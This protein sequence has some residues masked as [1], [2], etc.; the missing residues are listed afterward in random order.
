[1]IFDAIV[2]AG[3]GSTR[4]G[5]DKAALVVD[6]VTMLDRVL[7]ATAGAVSTVVVGPE[8]PTARPVAWTVEDPPGGGPVAGIATGLP[9]GAAP[10]VVVLSC[11]LPWIAADDVARLVDGLGSLD[12]GGVD[13]FGLRDSTGRGQRLAAAYRR[14]ALTRAL[15]RLGNPRDRA[16]RELVGELTLEWSSPSRAGDDVDTWADLEG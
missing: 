16:V 11:D 12:G 6:G 3:G 13:G 14:T 8:R 10:T 4:L 15:D 9:Y 7:A 5:T 2:L 1:V